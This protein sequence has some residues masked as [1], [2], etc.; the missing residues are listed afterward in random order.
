MGSTSKAMSHT[1]PSTS[2]VASGRSA[3]RLRRLPAAVQRFKEETIVLGIKRHGI[4]SLQNFVG[5]FAER[6]DSEIG[7][8]L[9]C[10]G[11]SP[12]HPRLNVGIYTKMH[13]VFVCR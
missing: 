6:R 13:S 12:S 4:V 1:F 10:D 11:C 2:P 8:S 5:S 9:A 3:R 7:K